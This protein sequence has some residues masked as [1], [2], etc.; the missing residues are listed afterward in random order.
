MTSSTASA[1]SPAIC[2]AL[3][4]LG[5]GGTRLQPVYVGD[6][7]Q[8]VAAALSG[9]AKPGVAYELGGPRTMTLREAAELTLRAIDRRRLLIGLP[10]G[11]VALDRG[12]DRIRVEGDIRAF[13]ETVDDDPRSSR[14]AWRRTTSYP[15]RRKPR[16]AC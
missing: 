13:P 15:R 5:G 10:L 6:I 2:P 7:G 1:L 9:A 16:D 11:S 4:L 3:P 12:L 14:F 8:A